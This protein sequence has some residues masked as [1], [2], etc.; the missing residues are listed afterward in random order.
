MENQLQPN[1]GPQSDEIDLG[2]LFQMIRR[3]LMNLF[4]AFLKLFV[5]LK[6]NTIKLGILGIVGLAIGFGLNQIVTKRQKT[7]VIVKPNLESKNY[8]YDVVNEIQ[9]NIRAKDTV[10]FSGIGINVED[11]I[12]FKIEIQPVGAR[13]TTGNID[14]DIKYLELLE[15]FRGDDLV[16]DIVRTELLN[17]S[18]LNHR[19]TFYHK[20]GEDGKGIAKKLIEYINSNDYFNELVK[21]YRDN[22]QERI[23]QDQ[24][25]VEQI[26]DMV[27]KYSEKMAS[28]DQKGEGRIV[29][30]TEEQL[31][32][33]GLLGLKNGLIRDM[34]RKKLEI[35]GQKE[36]IR[37][38]NFGNSQEVQ[39]SFFGKNIVLIPTVL[40][41]LFFLIDILKFFNR[42]AKEM[43]L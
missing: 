39:K 22:A 32:I 7:E 2:Q 41:I 36:A 10:F 24:N 31:D 16:T 38:I 11:L 34:E 17:K 6:R 25:L 37:I 42:K 15:K 23:R 28:S 19:I 3:G 21:I 9:S 8:L 26:D 12:G 40:I 4:K 5:Y 43:Q 14:S 35:Q 29:L 33:T 1:K 20:N 13:T 18:T 27:A 30:D